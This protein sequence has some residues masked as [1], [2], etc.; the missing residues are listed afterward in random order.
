ML[1]KLGWYKF[2]LECYNFRM[3]SVIPMVTMK[4]IAIECAERQRRKEFKYFTTKRNELNMKEVS[5]PGNEGQNSSKA[6]R[7]QIAQ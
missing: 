7:K 2:R 5:N 6:Y 4:K 3:F 1:L